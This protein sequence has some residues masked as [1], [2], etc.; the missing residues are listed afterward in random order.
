MADYKTFKFEPDKPLKVTFSFDD[1]REKE[2]DDGPA[3]YGYAVTVGSERGYINCS[4][5]LH[6]VI[7]EIGVKKGTTVTITKKPVVFDSGKPGFGFDVEKGGAIHRTYD[8]TDSP[9]THE[10]GPEST[11]ASEALETIGAMDSA[12]LDAEMV[13]KKYISRDDPNYG[14][15]IVK[16]ALT[17]YISNHQ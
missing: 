4:K 7:Q 17:L 10:D 9:Q 14:Y 5:K 1:F 11:Q 8:T 16:T 15:A 3:T 2:W 13:V 12:Y 6:E